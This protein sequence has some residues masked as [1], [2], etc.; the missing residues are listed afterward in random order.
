M[1]ISKIIMMMTAHLW[2]SGGDGSTSATEHPSAVNAPART[3]LSSVRPQH[4]Q[5]RLALGV[6]SPTLDSGPTPVVARVASLPVQH[7]LQL[8]GL[9]AGHRGGEA[10]L[11]HTGVNLLV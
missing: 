3:I 2:E 4:T 10:A 1:I 8:R 11:L 7:G 9:L 5:L 6:L